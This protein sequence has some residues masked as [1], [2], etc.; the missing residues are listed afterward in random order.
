MRS[1]T[2]PVYRLAFMAPRAIAR[3][4]RKR[5]ERS[6]VLG[7]C[8]LSIDDSGLVAIT[9]PSRDRAFDQAAAV[10]RARGEGE[11]PASIAAVLESPH[12]RGR[13]GWQI[14][15]GADVAFAPTGLPAHFPLL[16][17]AAAEPAK[18]S[19]SS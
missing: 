15:T 12:P 1:I 10:L 17:L 3:A 16:E 11:P 6:L 9:A 18:P 5:G 13:D 2:P 8:R 19:I 7:G 14:I 4:A